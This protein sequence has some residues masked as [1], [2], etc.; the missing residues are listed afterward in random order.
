[1]SGADPT[2]PGFV[3]LNGRL[4]EAAG[5]CISAFDQGFLHG[6]GLFET[7]RA[8][9]G[10]V[11]RLKEHVDRLLRS[12]KAAGIAG[13]LSAAA[14]ATACTQ[15]VKANR[16][17]HARV[18]L[19]VTPGVA[20][21]PGST[22][23]ATVM[24]AARIYEPYAAEVYRRGFSATVAGSRKSSR[25]M[26]A[27]VKSL[28]YMENVL[29]RA[30]ASRAGSDE[31][32]FLN[33]NGAL[34]EGTVSNVFLVSAGKLVTPSV[35]SGL[36]AGIAR[37]DVMRLA[38]GLDITVRQEEVSLQSL[39]DAGEAFLTNSLIEVMPLTRVDGRPIGAGVPGPCTQELMQAYRE[40]VRKSCAV[41]GAEI[42]L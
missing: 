8:Y 4:V 6:Y 20:P 26:M 14:L 41:D 19:T 21:G 10:I 25:S 2:G 35:E 39:L 34:T 12:A 16:L 5:A 42:G 22:G 29:A 32:L 7:M 15:T 37:A 40:M 38:G 18:R 33:E 36:L 31:A 24:V 13:G 17:K 3:Y 1:M 30:E 9:D 11:F 23:A 28:C 27:G